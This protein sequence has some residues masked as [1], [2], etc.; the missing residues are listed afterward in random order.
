MS[1]K[2]YLE[3]VFDRLHTTQKDAAEATG[4]N[5]NSLNQKL[6]FG[7]FRADDFI[8]FLD[9]LGVDMKLIVRATGEEIKPYESGY[10]FPVRKMV[11]GVK[12]NTE[13]SYALSNTY[14]Q[15]G[16]NEYTD[17]KAVELYIDTDGRYFFAERYSDGSAKIIP[18]DGTIAAPFIEK[19]GTEIY[20]KPKE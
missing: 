1:C 15:D 10:G 8:E 16:E 9:D 5:Y 18:V 17:G 3:A 14:Y 19:Y 12:Y 13:K 11:D 2:E 7:T 20:K 4:R 6:R